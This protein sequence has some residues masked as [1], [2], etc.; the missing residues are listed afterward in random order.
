MKTMKKLIPVLLALCLVFGMCL[1]VAAATQTVA[2]NPVSEDNATITVNNPAKGETY[3]VHKLFNASVG[4]DAITY[5]GT[6]PAALANFFEAD[7]NGVISP[8]DS[9]LDNEGNAIMTD[10]LK[11]ALE[12]WAESDNALLSALSDGSE[13]LVF[14]GLDFGY[15]VITTTNTTGTGAEAKSAITVTSTKPNASVFDKNTNEPSADKE[16]E[17]ESYSIGDTVKYTAT[18]DTTNYMGEGDDAKQVVEYLIKDTLP[19]FIKDVVVTS[20]TIG[21]TAITPTPQFDANKEI[22][23][24]WATANDD[25]TYTSK[26]VQGA[27]IVITYEGTLTDTVRF[28]T[29]NT[30]TISITPIVDENGDKTPWDEPW[31]DEEV[32]KTYAAALKKTDGTDPLTGAQFTVKG[33]TVT[34]SNG[35]YTVVSYDPASDAQSAVLDTDENGMLYI[36]GL[37]ENVTLTVTEVKAP[38]GYNLLTETIDVPAQLLTSEIH[39]SSG[40]R[41]YDADGNLVKEESNSSTSAT[42][43][44]NLSDLDASAVEVINNTGAE[45]PSTGGIGTTIFYCVGAILLIGAGLVLFVRR[46]VKA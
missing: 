30:N 19:E 44:K 45:L 14:T 20:F 35:V 41:Y 24:E 42:V 37:A 8:K 18:F 10:D 25:D 23:V 29:D 7:E 36:L 5:N 12:E 27:K 46:R 34:G 32:V 6:V 2:K 26:Y 21:G 43:S 31:T 38:D 33:L 40:V 3:S 15:Y 39:S 9:I 13:A 22:T 16:V 4:E 1:S 11:A 28:G 17:K